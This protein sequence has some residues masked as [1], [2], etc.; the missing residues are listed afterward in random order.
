MTQFEMFVTEGNEKADEL[1]NAGAML[2][3][4]FMA[5]ARAE[6]MKQWKDGE[7]LKPKPKEKWS[8]VDKKSEGMKHRTG[9]C[10][11]ADRY[12]CM[13][14]GRG[15]KY[16][17]MPGRCTGPKCL[18]KSLGKGVRRYLRGHDLVRRTDRQGVRY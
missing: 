13:R 14:C 1:A 10:A 16:V 15:S 11:E 5:E 2:D 3:E 7:E 17:K 18:S 12:R 6:T 4:A 8:F 9:W